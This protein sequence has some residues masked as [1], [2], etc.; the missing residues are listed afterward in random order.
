V[1]G[2]WDDMEEMMADMSAIASAMHLMAAKTGAYAL[3]SH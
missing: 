2:L 1:I 3:W